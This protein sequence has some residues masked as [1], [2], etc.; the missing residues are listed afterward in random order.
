KM[1]NI[2]AIK[3]IGGFHLACDARNSNAVATLRARKHRPAKPLAVMLP[4]ADGLP[5]AARQLLTTPAAPI[6]L[7]DKKYVP[8]L[9]DDIAPGLNE[10]GVMLPA[11]PLQHLLLQELQCP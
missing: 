10:V 4:V 8:E 9:C 11:N 3:G 7:V 6:V 1:G 2:V 5:D